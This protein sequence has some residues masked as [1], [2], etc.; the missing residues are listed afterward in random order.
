MNY[1]NNVEFED[2]DEEYKEGAE[3]NS[4]FLNEIN[5]EPPNIYN[6][7]SFQVKII[8]NYFQKKKY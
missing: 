5:D 6:P 1:D 7:S 8:I 3:S 4:K 2:N